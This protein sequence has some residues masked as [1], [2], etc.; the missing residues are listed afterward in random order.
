M[1]SLPNLGRVVFY[2]DDVYLLDCPTSQYVHCDYW[3]WT[4]ADDLVRTDCSVFFRVGTT[5]Y[6]SL[7]ITVSL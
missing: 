2:T 5:G 7:F 1:P 4:S 3:C 6:V